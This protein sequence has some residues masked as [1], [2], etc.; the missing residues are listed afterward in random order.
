MIL[1]VQEDEE[2][3]YIEFPEGV[4]PVDWTDGTV[5][6]W[7]G[8]QDGSWTIRKKE[9]MDFVESVIEFNA[10]AG[11]GAEFDTRKTALY[12]GLQLEEMA[13]KIAAIE[14]SYESRPSLSM[15]QETL[16]RFSHSFKQGLYDKDV[17]TINRVE[18]LDA[19][20]DLAV[21][22]LG[23][24]CAMGARVQDAAQ[25]VMRSNLSKFPTD[26]RGKRYAEKDANGKVKKAAG[27]T[28]PNLKG[29]V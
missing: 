23:G 8:N 10:I 9:M 2:G 22:A 20:I 7:V 14:P 18:A 1:E 3:L 5:I 13:E 26:I 12:I 25:E 19:D 17:S 4:L 27:Y 11:T 28:P 21:V 24:A 16:E 29:M 6:E 15:L